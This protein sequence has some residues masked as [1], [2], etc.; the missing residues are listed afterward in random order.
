MSV[1]A[2]IFTPDGRPVNYCD[3]YVYSHNGPFA[4]QCSRPFGHPTTLHWHSAASI[5]DPFQT[6]ARI[7]FN[8]DDMINGR[9]VIR[10][11]EGDWKICDGTATSVPD[12]IPATYADG[13]PVKKSKP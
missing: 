2:S 7:F 1:V 5:N 9:K 8:D 11:K 3:A 4:M 12:D 6:P 13:T 10:D